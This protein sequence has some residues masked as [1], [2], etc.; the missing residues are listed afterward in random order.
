VG[1]WPFKKV[2]QM[3][4]S[5]RSLRSRFVTRAVAAA[6][7]TALCNISAAQVVAVAPPTESVVITATR[8][9]IS[10]SNAPGALSVVTREELETR[11]VKTLDEA[12]SQM[13][14]VF[15][16]RSKGLLD[17]QGSV[18]LRG[19]PGDDRTLILL[20]GLPLNDAYTGGVRLGGLSLLDAERV[21][22]LRGPGSSLYG[23]SAVGGVVQIVTRMPEATEARASLRLGQ[24]LNSDFGYKNLR[25]AGVVAGTKVGDVSL[26][27]NLATTRTD[28]YRSDIVSTT[29]VPPAG[30][31][32][33]VPS[34]TTTGGSTQL[35][36]ERGSNGFKDSDVGLAAR[37]RITQDHA[38]NLRLRRSDYEYDYGDPVSYLQNSSGTPVF[39]YTSGTSVLREAAFTA[40]GGRNRRDTVQLLY[41]G[42]HGEARSRV[43]LALIDSGIAQF[44]TPNATTA[45]RGGGPG[46][47]TTTPSKARLLDAQW[48]QPL[49]ADHRLVVGAT[50]RRDEADVV[51]YLT[52]DWRDAATKVGNPVLDSHGRI[53]GKAL[54][55]QDEW[56]LSD[57]LSTTLGLRY[58]QFHN[59]DGRS[60]DRT[61]AGV[62]KGGFPRTF[63][64]RQDSAVSPKLAVVWKAS[65][66]ITWRASAGTAFRAPTVFD[67]YRTYISSAGTIFASNPDLKAERSRSFDIGLTAKPIQDLQFTGSLF[68]TDLRDAQYRR[69]VTNL[70]EARTLCGTTATTSNCRYFVN[71]GLTR[72]EGVELDLRQTLGAW[73][74]FANAT[75]LKTKVLENAF[76][77]AS[78]GKRLVGVPD[79]IVNAGVSG[80]LGP[81]SLSFSGRSF[82]KAYRNDDNGDTVTGV[83]GA[84][85]PRTVFDTKLRWRIDSHFTASAAVDNLFDRKAYDF[86]RTAGR[87]L[88]LELNATY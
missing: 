59:M 38:L 21:E 88:V 39:S 73:Q 67:L 62:S 29:I 48:T 40:G 61:D 8:T 84:T 76:A 71:A 7:T 72:S 56:S 31:S 23:G 87:T 55:V 33:A 14:G 85:D 68:R 10:L 35:I 64:D 75:L 83:Y 79:R 51:E 60:D 13:P 54:F 3:S 12:V 49:G 20:D 46:R 25:S 69:T 43:S 28:G 41:E 86:Y 74:W 58:D 53:E 47:L 2:Q 22:V 70:A 42:R 50:L 63:A 15:A 80:D 82:S 34:A 24:P 1:L 52:T 27:A 37:W 6:S 5:T 77:P 32:G 44:I 26:R 30:I 16:K 78:V 17:T 66:A 18:Q 45:T 65:D 19:L 57:S 9:P 81:V 4:N 11:N 36:G